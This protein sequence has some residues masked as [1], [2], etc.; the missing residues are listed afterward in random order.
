MKV[1]VFGKRWKPENKQYLDTLMD[2]IQE[3]N[4]DARFYS[5]FESQIPDFQAEVVSS[6]DELKKYNP[7]VTVT[8]GGDGTILSAAALIKNLETP[9]LGI[10]MGRLGF[11]ASIE[12]ERVA[13]AID[14]LVQR[15]YE[16]SKRTMLQLHSNVD[17]YGKEN[18]ALNDFTLLK[19]DNSSM[20]VIHTFIDEKFLI[21]YWAD[22]L[23][24]STPTG[25]TAYS[26]SCGGPITFPTTDNF[27]LTPVA[28]HNLNVRPVVISGDRKISFKI[29]GRSDNFLC[30]LDGRNKNINSETEITLSK[31][32][33]YSNMIILDGDGFMKT[34]RQKLN[35]GLDKRN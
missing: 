18:F 13:Q 30:A 16:I 21:S 20:I 2:K 32:P 27:I 12:Q 29:E 10:N 4:I 23:I 5:P 8:L 3:H 22:G 24:V 14:L 33:F 31:N 28:P 9:I 34:I 17:L 26:L 35:W 25:S 11:L 19:R 6:F 15:K 7:D 1:F